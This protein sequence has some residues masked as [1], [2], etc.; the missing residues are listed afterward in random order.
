MY[1]H[2][3]FTGNFSHRG[4]DGIQATRNVIDTIFSLDVRNQGKGSGAF[5]RGHPKILGLERK[6][7]LETVVFEVVAK[8]LEQGFANIE[9]GYC[10]EEVR[11]EERPEMHIILLQAGEQEIEAVF[12]F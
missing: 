3:I 11:V 2:S 1:L 7:H 4:R 12:L 6:R 5:P 9:N 8:V 10:S